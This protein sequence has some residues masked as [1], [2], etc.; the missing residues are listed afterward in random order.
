MLFLFTTLV[1]SAVDL[2]HI[3]NPL[4]I[5]PSHA[6]SSSPLEFGFF[7]LIA[8]NLVPFYI[9]LSFVCGLI[10]GFVGLYFYRRAARKKLIR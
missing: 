5:D 2:A 8:E 10:L 4:L 9:G 3:Q 1:I 6:S 7:E